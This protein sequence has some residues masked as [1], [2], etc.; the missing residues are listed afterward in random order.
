MESIWK[1]YFVDLGTADAVQFR[2]KIGD[3][4]I[5]SGKAYKRPGE[6]DNTIRINDICADYLKNVLPTLSQAA[7]SEMELPITFSIECLSDG[8]WEEADSVQFINDWSYDPSYNPATMGMDA[9]INGHIDARQWIVYTAINASQIA[10]TIHSKNGTSFQVYIPIAISDDFNAD[11]NNDFAKSTRSAG[12]GT[13]VFD[14]SAWDDVVGI[15]IGNSNLQVVTDCAEWALYYVNAYGGWDSF[16][17]EGAA[18]VVDNLTRHTREMEY[19]NSVTSNRGKQNFLNE[20]VKSYSLV[21]GWLADDESERMHHLL[22]SPEVFL[23]NINSGDMLPVVLT[24]T[25]TEY[26]TF[27]G[28]GGRLVNYTIEASLAQDRIR[29]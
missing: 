13:A 4:I 25:Q 14:L 9:P 20:I 24:N 3:D 5:Y 6:T 18:K 21:T 19:D 2:I 23:Y 10:A 16:L 15:T 8:S 7:F 27:K 11:F 29:R 12:S 26:K 17:I 1:D 28:N 22:N